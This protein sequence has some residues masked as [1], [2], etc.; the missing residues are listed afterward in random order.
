MTFQP[1][2][3]F[4]PAPVSSQG[5][6]PSPLPLLVFEIAF[7][8]TQTRALIPISDDHKYTLTGWLLQI[9]MSRL[10]WLSIPSCPVKDS[11]QSFCFLGDEMIRKEIHVH[12]WMGQFKN[13][14]KPLLL[15][16]GRLYTPGD[17]LLFLYFCGCVM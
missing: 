3:A 16:N 2:Y 13:R 17:Q 7:V 15:Q 1:S 5:I 9:H 14:G 8:C 10:F 12:D 4:F 6:A 11:L